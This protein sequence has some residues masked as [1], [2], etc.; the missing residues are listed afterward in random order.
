M[1][2][3]PSGGHSPVSCRAWYAMT[4][5]LSV[6]KA[7]SRGSSCPTSAGKG[8]VFSYSENTNSCCQIPVVESSVLPF[9][10]YSPGLGS[11]FAL[12]GVRKRF[13]AGQPP[14]TPFQE[15][16]AKS[17]PQPSQDIGVCEAHGFGEAT[18]HTPNLPPLLSPAQE[19][20]HPV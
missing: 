5:L 20:A 3:W 12:I 2:H 11:M 18:T 17:N 8:A 16:H 14:S 10:F 9:Q 7:P 4:S 15:P 19:S 1:S 6:H 13:T